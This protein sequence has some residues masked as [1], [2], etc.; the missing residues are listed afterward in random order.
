M[1]N[2]IDVRDLHKIYDTGE[3]Q[4]HALKGVSLDDRAGEFV[5][6][7]GTSGSGKSTLM[8]IL[9]CLDR[10]TSGT[11]MLDGIDVSRTGQGCA[12]ARSGTARSGLCF[13]ATICCAAPAQ[14]RT[15]SCHCSTRE[16]RPP[17]AWTAAVGR[18]R[19]S[20]WRIVRTA[21]R[22]SFR[23]VSSSVSRLPGRW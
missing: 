7:M 20:D 18:W 1:N 14:S 5:A 6:I 3:V 13:R 4:V 8:N 22:T 11:Y 9:G 10:P 19:W 17:S 16:Y 2:V 21:I 23:A 15:S 12:R